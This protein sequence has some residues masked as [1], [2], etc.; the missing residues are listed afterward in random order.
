MRCASLFLLVSLLGLAPSS[1]GAASLEID[2][3]IDTTLLGRGPQTLG[4]ITTVRSGLAQVNIPIGATGMLQVEN[5]RLD[6]IGFMSPFTSGESVG[7]D[8]ARLSGTISGGNFRAVYAQVACGG[9]GCGGILSPSPAIFPVNAVVLGRQ[10]AFDLTGD[11]TRPGRAGFVASGTLAIVQPALS[12]FGTFGSLQANVV[13]RE[14]GRRIVPSRFDSPSPFLVP[15]PGLASLGL[16]SLSA[17]GASR[18]MRRRRVP[19]KGAQSHVCV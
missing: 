6:R 18:W 3:E 2:F 8:L 4:P 13:G 15:E 12:F 9:P 1:G 7:G 14:I 19:A 11:P 16:L 5:A 10:A 17:L